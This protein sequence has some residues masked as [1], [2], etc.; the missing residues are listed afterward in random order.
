[1]GTDTPV[2]VIPLPP[3]EVTQINGG[4]NGIRFGTGIA[5]AVTTAAADSDTGAVAAGEIK[6]CIAY[7]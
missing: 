6:V 2:L 3:G 5:W 1:M 7:T 4:S